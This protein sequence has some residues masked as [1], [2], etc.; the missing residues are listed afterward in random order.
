M[1]AAACPPPGRRRACSPRMLSPPASN[2]Y[3]VFLMDDGF[4]MREYVERVLMMVCYLSQSDANRLMMQADWNYSAKIGTGAARRRARA[5][6]AAQGRAVGGRAR[7]AGAGA[8]ML[9]A[10]A[11]HASAFTPPTTLRGRLKDALV[12]N[13]PLR[14]ALNGA[15]EPRPPAP[16]P[17]ARAARLRPAARRRRRPPTR[18]APLRSARPRA[19]VV[20]L[21]DRGARRGDG[22]ARWV[23]GRRR[24]PRSRRRARGAAPR[25]HLPARAC[26]LDRPSAPRSPPTTSESARR[27]H[28]G[29]RYRPR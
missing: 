28:V 22:R 21:L 12:N 17:V 4:N 29:A 6:G 14:T 7:R 19:D 23:R 3:S 18:S 26:V 25:G 5:A 8:V 9:L 11:G 13:E 20:Q 24:Q 10:L 1:D 2:Q 15:R 27:S 16:R